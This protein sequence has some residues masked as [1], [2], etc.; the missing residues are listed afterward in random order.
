MTVRAMVVFQPAVG[1]RGRAAL[2]FMAAHAAVAVMAFAVGDGRGLVRVVATRAEQMPAF[3]GLA[4]ALFELL[5]LPHRPA[6]IGQIGMTDKHAH[7]A[8]KRQ[9]G[10]ELE[11]LAAPTGDAL[12]TLQM[13]SFTATALPTS[14]L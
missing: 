9:A 11:L 3:G 5:E 10:P 7:E 8:V 2:V 13:A 6:R 1:Q 4:T 14:A 12:L